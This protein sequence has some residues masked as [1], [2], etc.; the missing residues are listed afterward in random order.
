MS[1]YFKLLAA[2][3]GTSLTPLILVASIAYVNV[4][5][6]VVRGA[7]EN[8]RLDALA[9]ANSSFGMI[10]Q[11][12]EEV[13]SWSRLE[14]LQS[15]FMGEDVDL[16]MGL[17]LRD[18]VGTS[19]FIEIWCLDT[20]GKIVA[21]SDFVVVG[22]PRSKLPEVRQALSGAPYVSRVQA[23]EKASG[24]ARFTVAISHPIRGA[25]DESTIVGAVVAYYD[26]Q[27]VLDS[28][29]D[30]NRAYMSTGQTL[31]LLDDR[32]RVI[33]SD[34]ASTLLNAALVDADVPNPLESLLVATSPEFV[35]G[36]AL[37]ETDTLGLTFVGVADAKR[38]VVLQ[39]VRRMEL[40]VL[41]VSVA[42]IVAVVVVSLML[43]RRISVPIIALS[44][45]AQRI[46]G[47]E[48]DVRPERYGNDE[49]GVLANNLDIMRR[50]L[51]GRIESLDDTVSQRTGEL[52]ATIAQ[53]QEEIRERK[54][55]EKVA[56]IRQEQLV[57]ADKMVSLGILVSGVAH[58][59]NNPNG[60]IGLNLA[61][62][63]EAWTKAAPILEAYYRDDG[64]FSLGAM[65]YSEMREHL[66][67]LMEEM[68][69]GSGR[70]SSIVSDLKD[71]SRKKSAV[72]FEP[73]D[74]AEVIHSAHALVRKHLESYTHR[75]D[76][77][78]EKNL[79][80]VSGSFQRLEQVTVNLLLNAAESLPDPSRNITV[81][82][83]HDV[84]SDEVRAEVRDE[85]CGISPE[86]LAHAMD[87]FF[88]TKRATGGTGLGL[89]VSAAIVQDHEGALRFESALGEG[90]TATL[91]LPA[92]KIEVS[93]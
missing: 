12:Y 47:G 19:D 71:F 39:A 8:L 89:S 74:L 14:T 3:L 64:D 33:A 63:K 46:S 65:N 17:M 13:D 37:S 81:S 30:M 92:I 22:E 15:V 7:E 9:L 50:T 16:R 79:P 11:A 73:V 20:T 86:N 45:A 43:A 68:E 40:I 93:K 25:F 54:E 31:L 29:R 56:G 34:D 67:R 32:Y 91:A 27:S 75:V 52:E 10:E 1:I 77:E 49:I 48:L 69:Q 70:I 2:L 61:I 85:G 78:V 55:A 53:L 36:A 5:G 57:Q 60:L 42:A 24:E 62:L 38:G 28:V 84:G 58:E 41:G 80:R 83:Y 23:Y 66:P 82:V 87:P 76:I 44:R 18:L 6:A 35:R 72:A 4:R 90:T 21:S 59:I 88:T 26:W 51:K